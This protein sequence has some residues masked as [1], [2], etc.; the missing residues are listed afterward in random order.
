MTW[1]LCLIQLVDQSQADER[2]V[3]V[4]HIENGG[5][6]G[7]DSAIATRSHDRRFLPELFLNSRHDTFNQPCVAE[8]DA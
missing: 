4:D 7:E 3:R 6:L 2:D 8:H 5:L 1:P